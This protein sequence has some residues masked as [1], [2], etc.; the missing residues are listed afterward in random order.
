[1]YPLISVEGETLMNRRSLF[2]KT[3][4]TL[5][6]MLLTS[7]AGAASHRIVGGN[8]A[9]A[10]DYPWMVALVSADT[11]SAADGQFC[12]GSLIAP[13]WV[14]TAAHCVEGETASGVDAVIGATRLDTQDGER[15]SVSKIIPHPNYSSAQVPDVALL[16]LSRN[17]TRTPVD[18]VQ[19]GSNSANAGTTATVIGWGATSEDGGGTSR[20]QEVSLPIVSHNSCQNSYGQIDERLEICAGLSQGGRDSCQGDSGGPLFVQGSNGNRYL[21]AGVV[22]WGEGCAQPDFPGVYARVSSLVGWMEQQMGT[23]TGSGG[24]GDGG[25]TDPVETGA[26]TANFT[27]SCDALVCSFDASASTGGDSTIEEYVWDL[28]DGEYEYGR[29]IEYTYRSSGNYP[30][31]LWVIN[32]YGD[33]AQSSRSI[34]VTDQ[35]SGGGGTEGLIKD[36]WNKSIREGKRTLVPN[37]NGMYINAGRLKV[38]MK[39]KPANDFDLKLQ[40]YSDSSGRWETID[41]SA[42]TARKEKIVIPDAPAGHYRFKVI[43]F[44][45]AGEFSLRAQHR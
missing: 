19:P 6:V 35:V 3:S 21:Q 42:T 10:G 29:R 30:V 31:T 34:P 5:A 27:V 36:V 16:K 12:G 26:L 23:T 28:G 4:M 37:R 13:N 18:L 45:G 15:I 2:S 25:G 40:R 32:E 9:T 1:M 7:T 44:E 8:N 20:L 33:D 43:S 22:S 14:L 41:Y 39:H 24:N 17:S 11:S 38:V